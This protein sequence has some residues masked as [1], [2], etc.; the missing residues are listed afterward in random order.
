EPPFDLISVI[1]FSKNI[2]CFIERLQKMAVDILSREVGVGTSRKTSRFL[3]GDHYFCYSINIFEGSSQLGYFDPPL[4]EIG[5]NRALIYTAKEE[6]LR[7]ILRHEIGH[8]I[9]H[10]RQKVNGSDNSCRELPHG[11]EFR[12]FCRAQGWGDDVVR[13]SGSV[14]TMNDNSA[15]DVRAERMIGKVRKLLRLAESSNHHEAEL[16]TVK[17]NQI[18]LDYNLAVSSGETEDEDR[19]FYTR[20]VLTIKRR[21]AK[22]KAISQILGTFYVTPVSHR[23]VGLT[24]LEVTGYR[25]NVEIAGYVANFLDKKLEGLWQGTRKA[26]PH[27]KGMGAK[28]SFLRGVSHGYVDKINRL[29]RALPRPKR[30]AV[31]VVENSLEEMAKMVYPH[32]STVSTRV[33]HDRE[34]NALGKAAGKKLTIHKPIGTDSSRPLLSG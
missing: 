6:V 12:A 25:P 22:F 15:V 27:L 14:E 4:F 21:T 10:I 28:N 20:R 34:S 11:S 3:Y 24:H 16:A 2:L 19:V 8:M 5:I 26:H 32:L 1:V 23:G 9:V 31:M 7:N 30:N 33:V 17:A 18:L 29:K 13:A